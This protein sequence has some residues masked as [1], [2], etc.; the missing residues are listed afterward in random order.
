MPADVATYA[1]G[2]NTDLGIGQ[3]RI[4]LRGDMMGTVC[5][6]TAKN[7]GLE[8]RFPFEERFVGSRADLARLFQKLASMIPGLAT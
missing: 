6:F 5:I 7:G 4:E 8:L 2:P 3:D 1:I